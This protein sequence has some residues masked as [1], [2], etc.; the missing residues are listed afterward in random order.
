MDG[1]AH[2][3]LNR[4]DPCWHIFRVDPKV[5][6]RHDNVF[7]KTALCIDT[8]DLRVLTDVILSTK[9][10]FTLM[11][12]DMRLRRDTITE[13]QAFRA[14]SKLDDFARELVTEDIRRI[15]T[16]GCPRIPL[17]DMHVRSTDRCCLDSNQD[18]PTTRYGYRYFFQCRTES[19]LFFDEC[20]HRFRRCRLFYR[21]Y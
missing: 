4:S 20:T 21:R 8:D 14:F 17:I 19:A 5:F 6:F 9:T 12:D 11:T 16:R 13:L 10:L 18:F 1:I 3:L 15:D 2:W 7:R